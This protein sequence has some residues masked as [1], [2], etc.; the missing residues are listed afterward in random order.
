MIPLRP[1]YWSEDISVAPSYEMNWT[2]LL[3]AS[4][5]AK[6]VIKSLIDRVGLDGAPT[7]FKNSLLIASL[8]SS[9]SFFFYYSSFG[10]T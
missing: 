9:A 2:A 10:V 4:D 1:F 8:S 6:N 3:I 7:L 5:D